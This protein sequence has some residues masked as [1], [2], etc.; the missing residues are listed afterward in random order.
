ML[1]QYLSLVFIHKPT[2]LLG[3]TW[4]LPS[5]PILLCSP[6]STPAPVMRHFCLPVGSTV[7]CPLSAECPYFYLA[8]HSAC[9]PTIHKHVLP[10]PT[11]SLFQVPEL[12]GHVRNCMD[13]LSLPLIALCLREFNSYPI[14][15]KDFIGLAHFV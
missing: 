2:I 8:Q 10:R 5:P 12:P 13:G 7:F 1:C 3:T 15:L 9:H 14:P 6:I 11:F 4:S